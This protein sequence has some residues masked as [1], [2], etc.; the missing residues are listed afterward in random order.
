[1][2]LVELYEDGSVWTNAAKRVTLPDPE[3]AAKARAAAATNEV[4]ATVGPNGEV[5]VQPG[6]T[7]Q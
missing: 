7:N 4:T 5:S 2:T 6:I 1:M 3:A